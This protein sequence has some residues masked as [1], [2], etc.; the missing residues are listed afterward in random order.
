MITNYK[1]LQ[2]FKKGLQ[3]MGFE[4]VDESDVTTDMPSTHE[5]ITPAARPSPRLEAGEEVL[6]E[7]GKMGG[8]DLHEMSAHLR[9]QRALFESKLAAFNSKNISIN[10][11]EAEQAE[12]RGKQAEERREATIGVNLLQS[13]EPS[14]SAPDTR[15]KVHESDPY[16]AAGAVYHTSG[17]AVSQGLRES[18]TSTLPPKGRPPIAASR[19]PSNA[20]LETKLLAAEAS[21]R[22]ALSSDAILLEAFQCVDRKKKKKGFLNKQQFAFA[23][24]ITKPQLA[25][26]AE[27]LL[28]LKSVFDTSNDEKGEA[29]IDYNASLGMFFFSFPSQE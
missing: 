2:E 11:L 26:P 24:T 19:T 22:R 7:G 1:I 23:F 16:M 18:S 15:D 20:S 6:K 27:D 25:L 13:P 3:R 14:S 17:V 12:Q 5:R 29:E 28:T 21:L 4:L 9:Q 10:A 8:R